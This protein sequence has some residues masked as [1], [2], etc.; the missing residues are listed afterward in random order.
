MNGCAW[1]G[2]VIRFEQLQHA[3]L[4]RW[5][6]WRRADTDLQSPFLAPDYVRAVSAVHPG[7]RVAMLLQH[8]RA[9]AF[10]PFQYPNR[11]AQALS[12]AV[13]IG[14][15]MTD[16]VGVIAAPDFQI[17]PVELLR[18][19]GLASFLY[20]HLVSGQERC[21]L[22]AERRDPGLALT[23]SSAA[24]YWDE[25]RR[26]RPDVVRELTRR[27][28]RAEEELGPLDFQWDAKRPIDA[29]EQ[30]ISMKRAQ[31][32]RTRAEDALRSP[33]KREL[34]RRLADSQ[35]PDCTAVIS[36]LT[37]R[38]RLLAACFCLRSGPIL[39]VWFP[40]YDPQFQ[41]LSVGRLLLAAIIDAAPAFG[42][43][44][45]DRG[46]GTASAKR[47]FANLEVGYGRGLLL[48]PG[49]RGSANRLALAAGWRWRHLVRP[50]RNRAGGPGNHAKRPQSIP[51]GP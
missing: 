24:A 36:S 44:R 39:H 10:L 27:R 13:P 25:L 19:A 11:A 48:K 51:L 4:D 31:Y 38:D 30:L 28:R 16:A 29:L 23:L 12:H 6:S 21:G 22:V 45:I 8:G 41:R 18:A 20:T 49:L 1:S 26:T 37:A 34:L 43:S 2:E 17:G 50:R 35:A 32:R 47:D 9:V 46:V 33:W 42:V 15:A 14:G 40:V 3:E 7:A 5:R